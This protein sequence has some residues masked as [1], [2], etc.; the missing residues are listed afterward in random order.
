MET[1]FFVLREDMEKRTIRK[2][3]GDVQYKNTNV[4]L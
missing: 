3:L 1:D 2:I 4:Y